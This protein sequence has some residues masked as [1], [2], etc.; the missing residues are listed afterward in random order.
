MAKRKTPAQKINIDAID[1]DQA[2]SEGPL[3]YEM[4]CK[5]IGEL[6][7]ESF[8]RTTAVEEHAKGLLDQLRQQVQSLT[9]ENRALKEEGSGT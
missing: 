7:L 1:A 8:R 2:R 4:I 5:L 3:N 6:Y 9:E